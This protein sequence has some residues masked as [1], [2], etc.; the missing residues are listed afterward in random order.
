M[1]KR[2]FINKCPNKRFLIIK[3]LNFYDCNF[4]F[5]RKIGGENLFKDLTDLFLVSRTLKVIQRVQMNSR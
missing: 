2:T 1:D 3:T 5:L 4:S